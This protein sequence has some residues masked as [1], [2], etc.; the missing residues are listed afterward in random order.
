VGPILGFN[1]LHLWNMEKESW[2]EVVISTNELLSMI[3]LRTWKNAGFSETAQIFVFIY[4]NDISA[5]GLLRPY[6]E[7]CSK[8]AI[9]GWSFFI[10]SDFMEI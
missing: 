5:V 1:Y 8:Y 10:F 4:M 9:S 7:I 2:V 6:Q 3:K